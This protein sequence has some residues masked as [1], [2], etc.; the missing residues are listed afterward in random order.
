MDSEAT[1]L[2]TQ[3]LPLSPGSVLLLPKTAQGPAR[4]GAASGG[5]G[6]TEKPRVSHQLSFI[7]GEI[8]DLGSGACWSHRPLSKT[9]LVGMS[10]CRLYV[11]EKKPYPASEVDSKHRVPGDPHL[12]LYHPPALACS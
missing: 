8:E 1:G 9:E 10:A 5:L 2:F 7:G 4:V 3:R 12:K 11:G 6:W